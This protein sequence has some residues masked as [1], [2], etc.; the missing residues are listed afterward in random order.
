MA[1]NFELLSC[2]KAATSSTKVLCAQLLIGDVL[3]GTLA[4]TG[5]AKGGREGISSKQIAV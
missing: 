3:S 2:W 1:G 4:Y 5:L